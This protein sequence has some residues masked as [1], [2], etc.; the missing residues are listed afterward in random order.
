MG[1][2]SNLKSIV[3]LLMLPLV[4]LVLIYATSDGYQKKKAAIERENGPLVR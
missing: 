1:L 2:K 3:N 4:I